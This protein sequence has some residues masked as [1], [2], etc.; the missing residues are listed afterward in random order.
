MTFL[1]FK[2]QHGADLRAIG[3]RILHLGELGYENPLNPRSHS[4]GPGLFQSFFLFPGNINNREIDRM[5]RRARLPGHAALAH[6][7]D[8]S[9]L[10]SLHG[11]FCIGMYSWELSRKTG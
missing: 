4:P 9:H 10:R 3:L 1:A 2:Q 11:T 8:S 7:W 5:T 6:P